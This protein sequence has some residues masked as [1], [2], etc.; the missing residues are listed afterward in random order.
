MC[1]G[2]WPMLA[3]LVVFAACGYVE[4]AEAVKRG[5]TFRD[6]RGCPEMVVIPA[7][8]FVMGSTE[9]ETTREGQY[10]SLIHI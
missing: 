4:A 1:L 7:G 9:A 10:L 8:R 5:K 3:M 6:C 2:K